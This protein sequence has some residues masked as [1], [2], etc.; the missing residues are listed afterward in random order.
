[1]EDTIEYFLNTHSGTALSLFQCGQ[2]RCAPKHA[3]GPAIRPHYLFHFILDGK[4][5]FSADGQTYLLNQ[6]QGFLITPGQSTYYIADPENPWTYCWFGFDGYEAKA[7]L[8]NCGLSREQPIYQDQ[9]G[10]KLSESI[11]MM[12]AEFEQ[13]PTGEYA[14]LSALYRAFSCMEQQK[15]TADHFYE[16]NYSEQASKFIQNNFGYDIKINDIAKHIGIDRTYLYKSFIQDYGISPQQYLIRFRLS[17]ACSLLR[18]TDMTITEIAYSCG[19]KDT[20]AFYKHFK[21]YYA[22]TPLDYRGR[23]YMVQ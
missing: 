17:V 9:S 21:H 16:K 20:P 10:G 18:K 4:G 14:V 23:E 6:G 19:F 2:Q 5:K 3:F 15:K 13:T 7:I 11:Q 8:K 1:M 22:M 12:I